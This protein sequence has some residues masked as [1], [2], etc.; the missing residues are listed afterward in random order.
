MLVVVAPQ[1][2]WS[3]FFYW[4]GVFI[5][6]EKRFLS[7]WKWN[8]RQIFLLSIY[9]RAAAFKNLWT[10]Y[11]FLIELLCISSKL[12]RNYFK[13]SYKFITKFLWISSKLLVNFLKTSYEFLA[14]L[15][16][17]SSK[18]F[19][20]FLKTTYDNFSKLLV[21]LIPSFLPNF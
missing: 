11:E 9:P 12:L 3:R 2:H 5:S 7:E 19:M 17:I 8:F 14:K 18:V 10:F 21:N 15:S 16:W 1:I 13:T 4:N 20:D 6:F